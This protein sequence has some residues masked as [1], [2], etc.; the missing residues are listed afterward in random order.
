MKVT[1]PNGVSG[2]PSPARRAGGAGSGFSLPPVGGGDNAA[3]A[4]PATPTT[5]LSGVMGVDAILALQDVGGPLENRRRSV[6]RAGRLLDV[7]DDL[8]IALI[9]GVLTPDQLHALTR[10]LGEKREATGDPTLETVLDEIE[11]RAAVELAK[12]EF[13]GRPS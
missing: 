4:A 2:G 7:L 10:A 3:P 1:G 8:K 12:L 11:T 13:L 5:G 6:R 9:D